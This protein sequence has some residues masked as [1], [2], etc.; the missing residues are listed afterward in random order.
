MEEEGWDTSLRPPWV[1]LKSVPRTC[2][3]RRY[4]ALELRESD[5]VW[6]AFHVVL[7]WAIRY[8]IILP[9]GLGLRIIAALWAKTQVPISPPHPSP[10]SLSLSLP[11]PPPPPFLLLAGRWIGDI[12]WCERIKENLCAST[13]RDRFISV[14]GRA[15]SM[16]ASA[17]SAALVCALGVRIIVVPCQGEQLGQGAR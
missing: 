11:T 5:G 3:R 13:V 7:G 15:D 10:H 12:S 16:R 8:L 2:L 9:L 1:P 4:G 6:L 14:Q 17:G